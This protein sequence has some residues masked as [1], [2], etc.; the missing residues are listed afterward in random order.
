[1]SAGVPRQVG[2]VAVVGYLVL[3]VLPPMM[4]VWVVPG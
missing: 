3:Y 2:G 1:M 4:F